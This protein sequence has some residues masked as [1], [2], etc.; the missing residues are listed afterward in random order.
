MEKK[1]IFGDIRWALYWV[2]SH[3]VGFKTKAK[4]CA[5]LRKW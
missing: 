2:W 5:D 3:F 4:Q 1:G